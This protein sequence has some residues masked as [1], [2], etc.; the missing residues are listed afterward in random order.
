[1][2]RKIKNMTQICELFKVKPANHIIKYGKLLYT[3]S[4]MFTIKKKSS[5]MWMNEHVNDEYVKKAKMVI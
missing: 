1:M 3:P 2:L 4:M 5:K